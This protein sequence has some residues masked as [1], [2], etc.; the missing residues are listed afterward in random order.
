MENTLPITDPVLIFAIV[1]GLILLAPI[2]L[3]RWRLPGMI[4]LLIA[5][6]VL[7]PNGF[8]VLAR[9]M[10][11]VLFGTVGLLYIMFTAALEVDMA[12]L[13]RSR[14]STLIFGLLT[15][16]VPMTLGILVAR[17]ILGFNWPASLLLASTFASH[18]LLT[19]PIASRLGLVRNPAVTTAVG[20]TIIT[21]TLALLVLAVIAGMVRGEAGGAFWV[22][23]IIGLTIYTAAILFVLPRVAR[24]FFRYVARDGVAEF[25]FVLAVVFAIS[26]AAHSAGSEPIVGAFLAGLALNRLIPHNGVLMNRIQFTG[27]AIFVPFFLL[28]VGMLLDV[29]IFLGG[30]EAWL[31]AGSMVVTVVTGKFLAAWLTG[32]VLGYN[33]DEYMLIF[34]LS[35]PQAAAT[36]AATIVGFEIGLFDEFVVNGAIMMIFVSCILAPI[37]VQRHGREVALAEAIAPTEVDLLPPKRI[38]VGA[39]NPAVSQRLAELAILLRDPRS[40]EAVHL[41]RILP[42]GSVSSSAESAAQDS[43]A[44]VASLLSAAEIKT[45]SRVRPALSVGTGLLAARQ[46]IEATDLLIGWP[47]S[48]GTNQLLLGSLIQQ[49]LRDRYF[50]LLV[51]RLPGSLHATKRIVLALPTHAAHEDGFLEAIRHLRHLAGQLAAPIHVLTERRASATFQVYFRDFELSENVKFHTIES[52]AKLPRGLAK[53]KQPDDLVIIYGIRR[54][55]L[56]WSPG[57]DALPG[58]V[59]AALPSTNLLFYF[60]AELAP[61]GE[62]GPTNFVE[63]LIV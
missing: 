24:W 9:D 59:A 48:G 45:E 47:E 25:V 21:D 58:K 3:G 62:E 40:T 38:L 35:V 10:S 34:G 5:G 36:L 49:L 14:T 7:G 46:E 61:S 11:F 51:G 1:S 33:R 29:R 26:A 41:L 28:S 12:V 17:L 42:D 18:T 53:G 44:S 4:G 31:V 30:F 6:A 56:S 43:L 60:P 37:V 39:S 55:G 19:Y 22:Q 27:E 63:D 57:D 15:F 23:L 13:K 32:R 50:S 20:G 52:W 16:A 54:G 8:G 2:V